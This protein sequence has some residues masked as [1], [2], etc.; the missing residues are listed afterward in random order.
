[1][2]NRSERAAVDRQIAEI[3]LSIRLRYPNP[4]DWVFANPAKNGKQRYWPGTLY[5]AHVEP[6]PKAAGFPGKIGWHTLRHTFATLLKAN[7]EDMKTVQELLRHA[8]F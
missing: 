2:P 1:M 5:R 7:G 8:N 6:A 4:E 3:Q